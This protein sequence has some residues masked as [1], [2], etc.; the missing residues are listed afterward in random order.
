MEDTNGT[1]FTFRK[2]T[3]FSKKWGI[4]YSF[5]PFCFVLFSCLRVQCCGHLYPWVYFWLEE[6][7]EWD[8]FKG[9]AVRSQY[10]SFFSV[11]TRCCPDL[12]SP[13]KCP[14]VCAN[15]CCARLPQGTAEEHP[16]ELPVP[17]LCAHWHLSSAAQQSLP[18]GS[19]WPQGMEPDKSQVPH[20]ACK[21][22]LQCKETK[23]RQ[24]FC[25]WPR[26]S[27]SKPRTLMCVES[28]AS[29]ATTK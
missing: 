21:V 1:N 17:P 18:L 11:I 28:E 14:Q 15:W 12:L 25:T 27:S 9:S 8:F 20:T 26:P 19:P 3:K 4:S 2:L 13:L 5:S 24:G 16:L 29:P 22:Q 10:N 23:A 7:K 6:L